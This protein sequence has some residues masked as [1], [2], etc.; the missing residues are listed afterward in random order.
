MK[1]IKLILVIFIFSATFTACDTT[2]TIEMARNSKPE[3]NL[4]NTSLTVAEDGSG[5]ITI[6]TDNPTDKPLIFKL[7]QVSGNAVDGEDY[8][9]GENYSAP[10]FGPVGG[11]IVIPAYSTTGSVELKGVTDFEI[12]N[13][14]A[15]FELRSMESMNGVVGNNNRITVDFENFVGEDLVCILSWEVNEGAINADGDPISSCDQDLDLYLGPASNPGMIYS[16]FDCPEAVVLPVDSPDGEYFVS[17]D[18]WAPSNLTI[19]AGEEFEYFTT[20]SLEVGVVG[21]FSKTIEGTPVSS[22][23]VN[24]SAYWSYGADGFKPDV[25]KITKTG[26]TFVVE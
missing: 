9:F 3:V 15:V 6:S 24:W 8:D 21:L 23:Y 14:S 10:D 22:Q 5:M 26:T 12:D 20:Y 16:W 11:K 18:Y 1:Y 4:D 7:Y 19:D 25:S 2:D 17:V 13:K